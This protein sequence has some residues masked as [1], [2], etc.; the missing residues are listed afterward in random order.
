MPFWNVY[1]SCTHFHLRN[2]MKPTVSATCLCFDC[3]LKFRRMKL[4]W[5]RSV[6]QNLELAS[7]L[8]S[9]HFPMI[10]YSCLH[11]ACSVLS[12]S[13]YSSLF[14]ALLIPSSHTPFFSRCPPPSIPV[15]DRVSSP[16]NDQWHPICL[17]WDHPLCVHCASVK[18][19]ID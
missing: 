19:F 10:H 16:C 18:C 7:V 11:P 5:S 13:L 2:K 3:F 14:S 6:L 12:F 1:T 9:P 8:S 15:M 4:L 17:L